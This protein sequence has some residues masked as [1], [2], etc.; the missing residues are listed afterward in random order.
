MFDLSGDDMPS[1]V[2]MRLGDSSYGEVVGFST[3]GYE[4]DFGWRSIDQSGNFTTSLLESG[5]RSLSERVYRL[6][7]P[8]LV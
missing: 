5:L 7:V 4:N 8:H 2:A 1:V 6:R 3:P